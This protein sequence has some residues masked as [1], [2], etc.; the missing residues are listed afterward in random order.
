MDSS[1][2]PINEYQ[3]VLIGG[4]NSQ[5]KLT[6][7][8]EIYDVRE[9]TWRLFEIGLSSP[10][11]L[12]SMVSS[13]K[14]RVIIIGGKERDGQDSK[15]VEEIDFIKRNLVDLAPLNTGRTQCN[16]FLVNDSIF[17]FGGNAESSA[18][19]MNGVLKG[20]KFTM[21][22]NRWREVIF[23]GTSSSSSNSDG[24]NMM[25][26]SQGKSNNSIAMCNGPAAL[27]YE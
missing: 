27:L 20:E 25:G 11:R 22:E 1:A 3:I 16:A 24:G 15:V 5:N 17:V 12:V 8:V 26:N 23:K 19:Y 18:N 2:T 13:Q 10:R 7:L 4:Q 9:N 6:D 14:D 21:N